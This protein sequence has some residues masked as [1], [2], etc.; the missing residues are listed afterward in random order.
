MTRFRAARARLSRPPHVAVRGVPRG[1]HREV[2]GT[3]V[4]RARARIDDDDDDDD[5]VEDVK[6]LLMIFKFER[7]SRGFRA[8]TI[9]LYRRALTDDACENIAKPCAR[10][11]TDELRSRVSHTVHFALAR[12][13]GERRESKSRAVS[14]V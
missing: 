14:D 12:D 10:A 5:G 4:E 3:C 6:L 8:S 11:G 2:C 1:V 7:G 9:A 13:Q